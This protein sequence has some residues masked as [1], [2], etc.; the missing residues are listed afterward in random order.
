M[1]GATRSGDI[2]ARIFILLEK[3]A[4]LGIGLAVLVLTVGLLID[5]A[6]AR[7]VVNET[8]PA[9]PVTIPQDASFSLFRGS[10]NAFTCLGS[11]PSTGTA[12]EPLSATT[13][14]SVT[15]KRIPSDLVTADARVTVERADGPCLHGSIVPDGCSGAPPGP[16]QFPHLL[17][18]QR[19][20]MLNIV[21]GSGYT[22][23]TYNWT[24]RGGGGSGARGTVSV[25]GGHLGGSDSQA[26][27]ITTGGSGYTSRPTVVVSDLVSGDGG[28]IVP[29]VYQ[30]TPH[31]A[32]RPWNMPGVDYHVGI[33]A[34]TV[35]KDPT[36]AGSLPSGASLSAS[37]VTITGCD[38]TLDGYDFT[39][40]ATH[41]V[42]NVSGAN[43]TTTIQNSK[44]RANG[45]SLQPV[46]LLSNLGPGGSF[47]FKQNEYD[48][49]AQ[50]GGTGS[51]FKIND[52]IKGTGNGASI[53]LLYNWFHNFDSKVIQVSGA[54]PSLAFIEKY[55]L[56]ADY[57]YCSGGCSHGEAE[58]TYG[59]DTIA[60]TAE[61]NTYIIHFSVVPSDL[62]AAHAVQADNMQIDGTTDD[63]NVVLVPGPQQTCYQN[64]QIGYRAAADYFDGSQNDPKPSSLSKLTFFNNYLDNSG[65][66]F[67]WYHAT[68]DGSTMSSVTRSNNIDAGGG[69]AC[70]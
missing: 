32:A 15:C 3:S 35:L 68:K 2:R 26:Y 16:I 64:N 57:G 46:A 51:G 52:P 23:G 63:H 7:H 65:T 45:S 42:V 10:N 24:T 41:A 27:T 44:F 55:N 34:G 43:C 49:L 62:T 1:K 8:L 5:P 19:V 39:L 37:T 20:I 12:I 17:D 56:F 30:A 47:V 31:N 40:H 29:S 6:T 11:N 59:G 14:H 70:D 67:P 54:T 13:T 22:D 25:I 53:T 61:Y 69:G 28:V 58:Y 36:T 60:Y 38:V 4:R 66:Y 21:P 9:N 18:T 50:T 48:G 33:P